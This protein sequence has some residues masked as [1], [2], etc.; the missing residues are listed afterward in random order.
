[1]VFSVSDQRE[2][3]LL[4]LHREQR[5]APGRILVRDHDF[6]V[7]GRGAGG[8]S[9]IAARVLHIDPHALF[10]RALVSQVGQ[11]IPDRAV[12]AGTAHHQIR[13]DIAAG[14][15]HTGDPVP[16]RVG[17]QVLRGGVVDQPDTG[18]RA[19]ALSYPPLEKRST[20]LQQR[21]PGIG[22]PQRMSGDGHPHLGQRAAFDRAVG[23]QLRGEPREQFLEDLPPAGQQRVDMSALGDSPPVSR[24]GQI[25][26]FDHHDLGEALTEHPGGQQAAHTGAQHHGPPALRRSSCRI[27]GHFRLRHRCP[28]VSV[29]RGKPQY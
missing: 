17:E 5:Q 24:G 11:P 1:M 9:Q 28:A 10:R 14:D 15:P 26:A 12:A 6:L 25:V 23:D 27:S 18:Q 8:Q 3:V 16:G 13:R 29:P 2:D 4:V 7:R 22:L 21:I 19:D 20:G